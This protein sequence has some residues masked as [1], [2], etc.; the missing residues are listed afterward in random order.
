MPGGNGLTTCCNEPIIASV[1]GKEIYA[2]VCIIK[3]R[4]VPENRDRVKVGKEDVIYD[5]AEDANQWLIW[6]PTECGKTRSKSTCITKSKALCR[7]K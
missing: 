6:R 1:E 5:D 3:K 7:T 4:V 2:V